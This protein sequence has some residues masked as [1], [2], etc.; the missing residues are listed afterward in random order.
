[1]PGYKHSKE[2][3]TILACS[4]ATANMKI[5]LAMIGKSKNP[6]VFKNISKNAL[7][8]KYFNQTKLLDELWDLVFQWICTTNWIIL[9]N[10]NPPQKTVLLL[11]NATSHPNEDELQDSETESLIF[12]SKRNIRMSTYEPRWLGDFKKEI[13][14]K[15]FNFLDWCYGPRG[16]YGRETVTLEFEECSLLRSPILGICYRKNNCQVFKC[17]TA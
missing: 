1:M 15:S 12:V 9:K 16:E 11:D 13:S 2:T 17:V 14:K 4:N 5:K 6:G 8:V 10:N 7:P 3:V